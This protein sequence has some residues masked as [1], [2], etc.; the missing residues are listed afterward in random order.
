[1]EKVFKAAGLSAESP[2]FERYEVLE[3]KIQLAVSGI[4]VSA[5]FGTLKTRLLPTQTLYQIMIER[6]IQIQQLNKRVVELQNSTSWRITWPI[7][8]ASDCTRKIF[9][10]LNR[11]Q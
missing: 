3:A 2:D 1:M 11:S 4:H 10:N 8:Y 9:A 5:F 7:R 6:D